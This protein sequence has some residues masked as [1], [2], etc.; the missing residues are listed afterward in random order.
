MFVNDP[1]GKTVDNT[2]DLKNREDNKQTR[3]QT[4]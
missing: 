4:T 1:A 3:K 2:V